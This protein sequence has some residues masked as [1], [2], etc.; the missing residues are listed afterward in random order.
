MIWSL[1]SIL[2]VPKLSVQKK[3]LSL[4]SNLKVMLSPMKT[5]RGVVRT[6]PPTFGS[7]SSLEDSWGTQ[8]R[9][10]HLIELGL[11]KSTLI[12]IKSD[13]PDLNIR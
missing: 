13:S 3:T 7:S 2:G 6:V 4:G 8:E 1:T 11:S 10:Y 9:V 5:S 12:H